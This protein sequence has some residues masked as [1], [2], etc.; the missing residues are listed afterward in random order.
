MITATHTPQPVY[1]VSEVAEHLELDRNT[2][3]ELVK[4]GELRSVR[5]GRHIRITASAL[6]DFLGGS[7]GP[8]S[9]DAA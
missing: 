4:S 5:V 6:D 7:A 2:V 3:Y 8:T 9:P 1:R